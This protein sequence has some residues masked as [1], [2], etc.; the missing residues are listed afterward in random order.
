MLDLVVRSGVDDAGNVAKFAAE[1]LQCIFIIIGASVINEIEMIYSLV[2][3]VV[4]PFFQD[5]RFILEDCDNGEK[6]CHYGL[7]VDID[8]G[9][10]AGRRKGRPQL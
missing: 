7:Q 5:M 3:V 10:W 4:N 2:H 8:L 9:A 1:V 6:V